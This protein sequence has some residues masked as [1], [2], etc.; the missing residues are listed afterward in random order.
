MKRL[1]WFSYV[2]IALAVI[3]I[4]VGILDFGAISHNTRVFVQFPILL[5]MVAASASSFFLQLK[6][7]VPEKNTWLWLMLASVFTL[8]GDAFFVYGNIVSSMTIIAISSG[9]MF[10]AYACFIVGLL[11]MG[12]HLRTN[13]N[14]NRFWIPSI[15]AFLGFV[16]AGFLLF[17]S[18]ETSNLDSILKVTFTAYLAADFFLIVA[19]LLVVM[20]TLGGKL[21]LPFLM[22]CIGCCMLVAY[23]MSSLFMMS[24]GIDIYTNKIQLVFVA[25]LAILTVGVDMR[26]GLQREMDRLGSN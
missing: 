2:G 13:E 1:S 14:K 6:D 8:L 18:F 12:R 17:R 10:L 26:F 16:V 15:I 23:Q 25:A 4:F 3:A 7:A 5:L 24:A 11:V 21:S 20:R 19:N 22:I 9:L